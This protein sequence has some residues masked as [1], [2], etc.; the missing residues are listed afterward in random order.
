MNAT[1][2]LDGVFIYSED[3]NIDVRLKDLIAAAIKDE[4]ENFVPFDDSDSKAFS[5]PKYFRASA[6]E[7][8]ALADMLDEAADGQAAS[9]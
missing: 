3:G 4:V 5:L 1:L 2:G 9:V 7:L 6:R 8:R